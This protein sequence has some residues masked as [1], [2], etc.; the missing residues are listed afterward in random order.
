MELF[1]RRARVQV[2]TLVLD[3]LATEFKIKRT[4]RA[5]AGT[6]ELTVYNL[7]ED[8]R[9]E[10]RGLRRALVE[11]QAGH[12]T[13]GLSMLFR[14]DSR[15]VEVERAGTE[16]TVRVTAGDGEYSLHTARAVRSFAP[17]TRLA[18]VVAACADSLGVGRG[19]A[20]DALASSSRTFAT[21]TTLQGLAAEELTSLLAPDF[22]WSIQDGL[23]QVLPRGRALQRSA[24]VLSPSTGL[25]G[26]PK[27]GK[28]RVVSAAAIIQPDLQPGRLVDLRA[29][30]VSGVYRI[31]EV[32][33]EGE[34]HGTPWFAN[35]QLREPRT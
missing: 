21:G 28:G 8:H 14:G 6:C 25:V 2:G 19:N 5:R 1:G 23:L 29:S 17:G 35:L 27:I 9:A 31:E 24:V 26:S 16:W 30:T 13:S 22:E 12:A 33:F 15:K 3:G 4:T 7:N 32:E 10:L 18:D 34:T 20:L 11:V